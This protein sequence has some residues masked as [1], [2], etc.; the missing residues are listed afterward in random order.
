MYF[1]NRLKK[2][3]DQ[4]NV[5][6]Q[7]HVHRSAYTAQAVAAEEHVSGKMVA[8]TLVVKV[9]DRFA[10]AVLPAPMK[11][12]LAALKDALG[13]KHARLA[14]EPEF[15]SLF[16]DCEL[17]A[18]PPFG[19]LYGMPVYVEESLAGDPEIVFNAGTHEDTVQMRY[20]DFARLVQPQVL[21]FR[22]RS[23]A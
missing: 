12:D 3:L 1:E 23:A 19:N 4:Q 5:A 17:G 13:A 21:S 16:S 7:H 6:Y 14:S 10:M 9:D 8:K 22:L 15:Q 2:Y 11:L 20:E 18:M